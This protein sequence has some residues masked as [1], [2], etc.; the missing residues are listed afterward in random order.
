VGINIDGVMLEKFIGNE[1]N[2]IMMAFIKQFK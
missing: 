1:F 2:D